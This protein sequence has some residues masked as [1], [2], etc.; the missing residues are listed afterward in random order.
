MAGKITTSPFVD[1]ADDK[2]LDEILNQT[3]PRRWGFSL[4]SF[5]ISYMSARG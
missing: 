2:K 4:R 1:P 5:I 3:T